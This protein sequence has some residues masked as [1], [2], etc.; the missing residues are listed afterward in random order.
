MAQKTRLKSAAPQ[1]EEK[2]PFSGSNLSTSKRYQKYCLHQDRQAKRRLIWTE[3][4]AH[5]Q[6]W[7]AQVFFKIFRFFS[8]HFFQIIYHCSDWIYLRQINRQSFFTQQMVSEIHWYHRLNGILRLFFLLVMIAVVVFPFY[9]MISIA[10]RP[11]DEIL[12]G[13]NGTLPLWPTS[14]SWGAFQFLFNNPKANELGI[15]V[16]RAI[17]MSLLITF[18]SV[19]SQVVV[20]LLAGYGLASFRHKANSIIIGLILAAMI[21][22]T[23]SLMMGQYL[24]ITKVNLRDSLPA[25][26][27]PFIGNAFTIFMF[28]QAFQELP[29]S[30]R[31]AAQI[32][33]VSSFKFFWKI[34]LPAI[35][36]TIITA[37]LTAAINSWNAILWPTMV[38][39]ENKSY[40]T[41]PMILWQIMQSTGDAQGVWNYDNL[42]DPQNLKMAASVVAILP[43]M[44]LFL[45]TKK[46]LIKGLTNQTIAKN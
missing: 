2:P 17:L 39:Q 15:T 27:I 11:S 25:L 16:S 9:W 7:P 24:L 31:A 12:E 38:I 34:A 5:Q 35:K 6:R 43:M 29:S 36:A 1:L 30:L 40:Y 28:T 8:L 33:G 22:P 13:V 23:E 4:I 18:L 21:L 42:L 41:L 3:K 32:D 45:I 19:I 10:F 26:F 37:I 46:H 44:I 14:W 20:S